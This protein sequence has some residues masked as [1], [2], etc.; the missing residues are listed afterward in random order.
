[1]KCVYKTTNAV[2]KPL[3]I[4]VIQ[5]NVVCIIDVKSLVST[6]I[7]VKKLFLLLLC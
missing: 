6:K 5:M 7:I 3:Y 1:M 4:S 2:A